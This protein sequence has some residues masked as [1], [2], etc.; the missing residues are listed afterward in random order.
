LKTGEAKTF[1]VHGAP[2]LSSVPSCS[3]LGTADD[4]T[5]ET[6]TS[7]NRLAPRGGL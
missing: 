4:G 1:I 6:L 7:N 5:P 3:V 2:A